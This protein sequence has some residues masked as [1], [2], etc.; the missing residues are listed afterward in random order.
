MSPP[1][2]VLLSGPN[3]NLL[4]EREPA[5]YGREALDDHVAT[6]TA[7][8]EAWFLTLEHHQS[9]HEGELI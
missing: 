2:L 1:L 5:I 4:G 3:L 8:A 7:A 6:A 9:N